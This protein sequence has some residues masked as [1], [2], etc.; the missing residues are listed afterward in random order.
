MIILTQ[1]TG[2][3]Q[4]LL[5]INEVVRSFTVRIKKFK[6]NSIIVGVV[7]KTQQRG[8]RSFSTSG[9][10]VCYDGFQGIFYGKDGKAVLQMTGDEL[11]EGTEVKMWVEGE[12][13]SFQLTDGRKVRVH[14]CTSSLLS[15]PYQYFIEMQHAG[16]C[17]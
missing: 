9:N 13:M 2:L 14:T 4:Q 8:V 11:R 3:P 12:T 5:L 16:D 1:S 7:S 15:K 17:L 10:A 6:Y